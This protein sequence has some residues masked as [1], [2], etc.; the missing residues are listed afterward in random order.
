MT[1]LAP[2]QLPVAAKVPAAWHAPGLVQVNAASAVMV[3]VV[4]TAT[5]VAPD[6]QLVPPQLA[7]PAAV[8]IV[9]TVH[10]FAAGGTRAWEGL[11]LHTQRGRV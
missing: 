9:G 1:L 6:A 8:L 2:V 11:R 4:P 7:A 5:S 10:V 3:H